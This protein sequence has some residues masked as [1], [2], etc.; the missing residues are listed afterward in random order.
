MKHR[1]TQAF[2]KCFDDLPERVRQ[3][4]DK[5]FDLLK[6]DPDHPSLRFKQVGKLWSVRV[7]RGY[8]ALAKREA[9]GTYYWLWIGDHDGY[10]RRVRQG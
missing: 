10:L 1:A 5:Q 8:R 9:D 2:W 3:L 7:A 6:E 4:A